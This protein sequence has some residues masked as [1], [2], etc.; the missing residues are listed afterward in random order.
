MQS[1]WSGLEYWRRNGPLTEITLPN[2]A[3][4]PFGI[5]GG[6]R[7][8]DVWF[9][10]ETETR[11]GHIDYLGVLQ[12]STYRPPR[13]SSAHHLSEHVVRDGSCVYGS[14][15]DDISEVG[16]TSVSLQGLGS[17]RTQPECKSV[18]A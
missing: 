14:R 1:D 15:P 2:A 6:P 8:D 5:V 3:S 12:D 16:T 7:G 11:V 18:K 9:T 10:E 17:C 13:Q 4:G